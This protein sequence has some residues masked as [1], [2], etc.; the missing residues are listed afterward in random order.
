MELGNCSTSYITHRDV[1]NADI[2]SLPS[3]SLGVT[4]P[5]LCLQGSIKQSLRVCV[6]KLELGNETTHRD[7]GNADIV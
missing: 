3:S 6:T 7:V 1:G 5:K 4:T 2:F